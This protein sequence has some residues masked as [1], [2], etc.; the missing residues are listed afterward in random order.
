MAFEPA[1]PDMAQAPVH[2]MKARGMG[3]RPG[4]Q[5]PADG[6][7]RCGLQAQVGI[8]GHQTIAEELEGVAFLRLAEGFEEGL[9]WAGAV[10]T[11]WRLL[12]RLRA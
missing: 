5:D 2:P 9:E 12:P 11:A 1:W 8:F 7:T 10:N 6:L 3:D 4:W